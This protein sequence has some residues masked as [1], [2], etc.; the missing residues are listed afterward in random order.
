M[1]KSIF[2]F[3]L[4]LSLFHVEILWAY[5]FCVDGIYYNVLSLEELTVEVT[6]G[7]HKYSG[8]ITIPQTVEYKERIF[9][10]KKIGSCAFPHTGFGGDSEINSIELPIGLVE[11]GEN[12]FA[13]CDL[14]EIITIPE[15]VTKI[16]CGAF[17]RCYSLRQ[18]HLPN[19]LEIIETDLFWHCEKLQEIDWPES[20]RAIEFAAFEGCYSLNSIKIGSSISYIRRHAFNECALSTI[21]I[22][23]SDDPL[24]VS[25]IIFSSIYGCTEN[26][27]SIYLGRNISLSSD[28]ISFRE[29]TIGEK[30]S[31]VCDHLSFY[32]QSKTII[33][34]GNDPPKLKELEN[35]VY[36]ETEVIVPKGSLSAY[37][38]AESWKKFWNIHEEG[39]S[40]EEPNNC[41]MP[42]IEYKEGK[43]CISSITPDSKCYYSITDNDIV[44]NNIVDGDIDLSATYTITAYA[45]AEGY[46]R[47]PL[48]TAT[49]CWIDGSFETA[50]GIENPF[51]SRKAA[52][53]TVANGVVSVSGLDEGC[54]VQSFSIGGS[55][56]DSNV[57]KD[58]IATLNA[59]Q[60]AIIKIADKSI[61]IAEHK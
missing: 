13:Y 34:L 1:K 48:A 31:V 52:I 41:N 46:E 8:N 49:L 58:G 38:S 51:A 14:L 21:I 2:L 43:L 19:G 42:T 29:L 55:M 6:N 10:V 7:D 40:P 53:I 12:A 59:E 47:S 20:L 15:T 3:L 11:I 24:D 56:I 39:S 18:C 23:D 28:Y 32:P 22:N 45:T 61:K 5:D 35:S 54:L 26:V 9:S 36:M 57:A 60:C 4:I 30:V 16:G 50:D 33:C 44:N 27:L 25:D 17:S 37:Q